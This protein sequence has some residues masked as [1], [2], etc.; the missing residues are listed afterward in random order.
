MFSAT[1][2]Y[3]GIPTATYQGPD[4]RTVVYVLRRFLPQPED[5]S[6]I[7][8]HVVTP[9]QRNRLD[10]VA[11][12]ELGDPELSWQIADANRAMDP[13]ELTTQPGRRL[14]ITLPTGLP[15]GGGLLGVPRG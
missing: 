4:G 11:A 14:R 8:A 12:E 15:R 1:S 5:L 3:Q 2:R 7:G 9:G 13:D 10:L 6:P